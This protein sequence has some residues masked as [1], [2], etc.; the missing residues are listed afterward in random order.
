MD[1][2]APKVTETV[3]K[4][5]TSE[6]QPDVEEE[7]EDQEQS[8]GLTKKQKENLKK[9]QKKKAKK[10]N[11]K[12]QDEQESVPETQKTE[13][14]KENKEDAQDP[15]QSD[16]SN[17]TVEETKSDFQTELE[18]CI[19]QIRLGLS[20]NAINKDQSKEKLEFSLIF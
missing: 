12:E 8:Q 10:E 16:S 5:N 11:A 3:S 14:V 6:K 2:T 9:K 20:S 7:L 18:W 15:E 1:Q 17:L 4:D 19:K 13:E